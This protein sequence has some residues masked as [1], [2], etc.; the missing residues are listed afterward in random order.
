MG[1]SWR[2]EVDEMPKKVHRV[3]KVFPVAVKLWFLDYADCQTQRF[4][5]CKNGCF[6]H[7]QAMAQGPPDHPGKHT[8]IPFS[9]RLF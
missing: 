3:K 4:G 7:I 6:R 8:D 5:W 1:S 9:N 2:E